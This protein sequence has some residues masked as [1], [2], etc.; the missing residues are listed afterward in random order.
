MQ[1]GLLIAI[2]CA[3][4]AITPASARGWKG[5]P[6]SACQTVHSCEQ[7]LSKCQSYASRKP[8]LSVGCEGSYQSCTGTGIWDNP[9]GTT[10]RVR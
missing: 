3:T 4:L 9:Y 1:K 7:A 5:G 2:A 10:C 6:V 8:G